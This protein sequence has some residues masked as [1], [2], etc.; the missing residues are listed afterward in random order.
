MKNS[1]GALEQIAGVVGSAGR[2]GDS[3]LVHM[4]PMELEL[5]R[6]EWGEPTINPVTGLPEYFKFG[7][8]LSAILPIAVTAITGNPALGAIAAG[9][10]SKL[11]GGSW[12]DALLN[13]G[14]N[15]AGG[16]LLSG[17]STNPTDGGGL[18]SFDRI[19]NPLGDFSIEGLRGGLETGAN[20]IS[21]L[22]N[23]SAS[24]LPG[25]GPSPDSMAALAAQAEAQNSIAH[26]DIL[27]RTGNFVANNKGL[28]G[29][30]ALG[31]LALA[32][33]AQK[34]LQPAQ[35]EAPDPRD[36]RPLP[37]YDYEYDFDPYTDDYLTYAEGPEHDFYRNERY[38]ERAAGG[39]IPEEGALSQVSRYFAEGSGSGRDDLIHAKVSPKEYVMDAET[40]ALLGDGNPDEGARRMDE[41]RAR[42]RKH[43][44]KTLA[45][46]K[47]SPDA[48]APEQYLKG[49]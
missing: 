8:V 5:L 26:P 13:A 41:M 34:P 49:R 9:A 17:F 16:K 33:G 6:Q 31:A 12:K 25:I 48:H 2:Y 23:P 11:S 44:G 14:V 37:E 29:A 20:N 19:T 4:N 24:T 22:F 27:Q 3:E 38:I 39:N 36:H 40:M 45:R 28:L 42:V 18:F 32:G 7:K 15:Y 21:G 10:S 47:F 35:S 46:G 1:R 43:K 30:G